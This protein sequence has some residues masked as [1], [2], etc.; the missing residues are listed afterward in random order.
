MEE[1]RSKDNPAT[2]N[3]PSSQV[4]VSKNNSPLKGTQGS[5]AVSLIPDLGQ[6]KYKVSLK[7]P[8]EL[9]EDGRAPTLMGLSPKGTGAT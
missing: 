1:V 2:T 6:K 7:Y 5:F 3:T 4:V 8:A 9:R